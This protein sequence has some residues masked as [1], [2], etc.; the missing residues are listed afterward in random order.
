VFVE[1]IKAFIVLINSP[2][3]IGSNVMRISR[4][5]VWDKVFIHVEVSMS[6]IQKGIYYQEQDHV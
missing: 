2:K 4:V 5:K 6:D 1:G 3:N